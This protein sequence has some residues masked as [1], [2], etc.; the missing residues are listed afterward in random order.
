MTRILPIMFV[1]LN[2]AACT[3]DMT[4]SFSFLESKE[5]PIARDVM[6]AKFKQE[7]ASAIPSV[8][9][10]QRGIR[11]AYYSDPVMDPRLNTYA[12]CVRFNAPDGSGGFLGVK[13]FAAYYY[14]GHLN[15]LVA[16][17]PE[18]C[19]GVS[20][21]PFPELERLCPGGRCNAN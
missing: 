6:P 19:R 16:A 13:E 4:D 15:Q 21:K 20:Y 7:I 17:P 11:E 5:K 3:K 10:E 9:V 12:S 14:G 2:L 8:V 1:A 18:Q